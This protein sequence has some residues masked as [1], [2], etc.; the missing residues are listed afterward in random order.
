MAN[1]NTYNLDLHITHHSPFL[2]LV[3]S[4]ELNETEFE[5]IKMPFGNLTNK[6]QCTITS[7]PSKK[8]L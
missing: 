6:L 4:T 2:A 5:D 3:S 1:I 7:N 8:T